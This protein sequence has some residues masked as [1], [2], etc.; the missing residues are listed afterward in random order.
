MNFKLD[1][2]ITHP[3]MTQQVEGSYT[4]C[5]FFRVLRKLSIIACDFGN[6]QTWLIRMTGH[7]F[8]ARCLNRK[9]QNVKSTSHI[10]NSG[11]SK[12]SDFLRDIRFHDA[13]SLAETSSLGER[14][15]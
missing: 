4:C 8:I 3:E 13:L 15:R 5:I 7:D 10:R 9:A 12:D 1:P 2:T 11:R 6:T 14:N